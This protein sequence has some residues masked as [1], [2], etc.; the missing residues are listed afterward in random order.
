MRSGMSLTPV[1]DGTTLDLHSVLDY[2]LATDGSIEFAHRPVK[3]RLLRTDHI[4][5]RLNRRVR[6][7]KML[8][9]LQFSP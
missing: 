7:I 2:Y 4:V 8:D 5:Q 6:R 3:K 9:P 1:E